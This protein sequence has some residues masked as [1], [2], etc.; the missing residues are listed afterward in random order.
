[1]GHLT[2]TDEEPLATAR[3]K[4]PQSEESE[5]WMDSIP[6]I[7]A[8]LPTA[9]DSQADLPA[10]DREV[11]GFS[12]LGLAAALRAVRLYSVER[13]AP[14]AAAKLVGMSPGPHHVSVMPRE[15]LEYLAPEA[16]QIV[17]EATVG[18]GGHARLIAER[19][20]PTGRL[21]GLDQDPAMLELAR[22]VL[23]CLPVTLVHAN[24]DQ[25][26]H[27]LDAQRV[28]AADAVLA[29][30]GFSSDQLADPERGLSFQQPG[31]LDMRLD[32]T[33][34]EPAS[35]LLHRL[36]ERELANLIYLYGEER[37]SRRIARRVIE[38][39]RT[40]RIETTEQLAEL[41]RGCVPRSRGHA[42]DPATRTFQAL[43]IAVN[44]ELGALERLLTALPCCVKPGGRAVIISFH[45]LEDRRVK[46][47]FRDKQTWGALTRKPIQASEEEVRNNPRARS[48]KLRAAIRLPSREGA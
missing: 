31:P 46:Q 25:L 2:N 7:Q 42:I 36:N 24:F 34:G 5:T 30:L 19:L 44:D 12:S 33:Q 48:A 4:Q 37:L 29:D 41:V 47:A 39:R 23:D 17:V 26:R 38:V 22:P 20:G 27:V 9:P 40:S 6:R 13:A 21:I 43:R 32:P 15:V 16:G 35:A 14:R 8:G 18:G 10:P 3:R 1:V 45:S 28:S 11:R